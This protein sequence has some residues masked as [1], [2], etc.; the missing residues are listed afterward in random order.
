M[1]AATPGQHLAIEVNADGLMIRSAPHPGTGG[2]GGAAEILAQTLELAP[3][4]FAEGL[5]HELQFGLG[6]LDAGFI[7][8]MAIGLV[9]LAG[10]TLVGFGHEFFSVFRDQAQP[11]WRIAGQAERR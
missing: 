10:P 11:R 7:Q 2:I 1:M 5:G 9:G 4:Q 6:I 3:G 8:D